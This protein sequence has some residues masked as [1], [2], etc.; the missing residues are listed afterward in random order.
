M[1]AINTRSKEPASLFDDCL[2]RPDPSV[3]YAG[4]SSEAEQLTDEALDQ[5]GPALWSHP[6]CH[7]CWTAQPQVGRLDEAL[8]R[9]T[10][11][12]SYS[13]CKF[14]DPEVGSPE[15]SQLITGE[16]VSDKTA[17]TDQALD[18]P[19]E[20]NAPLSISELLMDRSALRE[21]L[22][23]RAYY[24]QKAALVGAVLGRPTEDIAAAIK[25]PGLYQS[26]ETGRDVVETEADP[27]CK[28]VVRLS[29]YRERKAA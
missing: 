13:Y 25:L 9:P 23:V 24:E 29:D 15:P 27:L 2:D 14:P 4:W 22:L 12:G 28:K 26:T 21:T 5:P 20:T 1:N 17:I 18:R 8:D 3:S 16:L 11:A 7:L 19:S 10:K 6:G